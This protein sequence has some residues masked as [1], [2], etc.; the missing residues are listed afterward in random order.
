MGRKKINPASKAVVA[1]FSVSPQ[2]VK[3]IDALV[4]KEKKGKSV[5]IQNLIEKEYTKKIGK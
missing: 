5:L 1:S 2:H 4:K 3:M